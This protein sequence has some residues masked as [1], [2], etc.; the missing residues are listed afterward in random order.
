[1]S[2]LIISQKLY[3][4]YYNKFINLP[5]LDFKNHIINFNQD[6]I[7][8]IMEHIQLQSLKEYSS[9]TRIIYIQ[10]ELNEI[11]IVYN[12]LINYLRTKNINPI[13]TIY[14]FKNKIDVLIKYFQIDTNK[15]NQ[16]IINRLLSIN[17]DLVN[18]K[19]YYFDENIN[20]YINTIKDQMKNI[21][22][23]YSRIDIE[24]FGK[25][26]KTNES[27]NE[28]YTPQVINLQHSKSPGFMKSP[29]PLIHEDEID[30]DNENEIRNDDKYENEIKNKNENENKDENEIENKNEN[31]IKDEIKD[32]NKIR[33]KQLTIE[34]L[35]LINPLTPEIVQTQNIIIPVDTYNQLSKDAEDYNKLVP[36]KTFSSQK[37][38]V[39]GETFICDILNQLHYKYENTTKIPHVG[40]IRITFDN[41]IVMFEIKNKKVI[42]QEDINKF[43]YDIN[44]LKNISNKTICGCFISLVS[45]SILNISNLQFNI[46]ET[47]IPHDSLN[48]STIQIYIESIK[49]IMSFDNNKL[50]E[51]KN[52]LNNEIINYD[53]EL[54]ICKK[55]IKYSLELNKDMINLKLSLENKLDILKS[56]LSG[57]NPEFNKELEVKQELI[58]YINDNKNWTLKECKNIIN[59]HGLIRNMKNKTDILIYCGLNDE[60]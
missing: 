43:K 4:Q 46:Y 34:D 5:Y 6:M 59:N 39:I 41:F 14:D 19:D 25:E 57:I 23:D 37:L 50:I 53:N 60:N 11:T 33:N 44:N 29:S 56:I 24:N 51:I 7:L 15:M 52:K 1:M 30:S 54:N 28:I 21:E 8:D 27:N 38:G 35:N 2:D 22:H 20:N 48:I 47:Y 32:E 16:N 26:F 45:N 36:F 12:N 58:N 55:H 49:S 18:I 40:D 31:K 10:H 42:T 17:I 13:W 9:K 3:V